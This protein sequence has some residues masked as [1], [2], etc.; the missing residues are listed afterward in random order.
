M[1]EIVLQSDAHKRLNVIRRYGTP[2][3]WYDSVRIDR[4][5]WMW[6][7]HN[8]SFGAVQCNFGLFRGMLQHKI[9]DL[10]LGYQYILVTS[11]GGYVNCELSR[12][13]ARE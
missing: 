9:G 12:N 8:R 7:C 2:K 5:R 3:F 13:L 1:I 6:I 11:D 4:R 10:S